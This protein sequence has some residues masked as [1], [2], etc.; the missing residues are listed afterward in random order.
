MLQFH[1]CHEIEN[2]W[3]RFT[4]IGRRHK[5][6]F[7]LTKYVLTI[8][9]IILIACIGSVTAVPPACA[10]CSP[11]TTYPGSDICPKACAILFPADTQ[12]T[13]PE[14]MLAAAAEALAAKAEADALAEETAYLT[15][16]LTGQ[17]LTV[18]EINP[19]VSS[20]NGTDLTSLVSS[21]DVGPEAAFD[22]FSTL[23]DTDLT[24]L[25]PS[26]DVGTEVPAINPFVDSS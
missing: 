16:I 10:Q 4:C 24:S 23:N 7:R 14:E 12:W 6:M 20:L 21:F 26:F 25:V 8:G 5:W 2:D 11:E 1:L 22:P 13:Y 19:L 3:R 9:M 18:P 15:S 17:T